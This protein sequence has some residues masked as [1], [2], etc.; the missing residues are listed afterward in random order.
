MWLQI[1]L[2]V[3]QI[4]NARFQLQTHYATNQMLLYYFVEDTKPVES[5]IETVQFGVSHFL[6]PICQFPI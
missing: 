1:K 5:V 3:R 2:R 6:Q 4:K